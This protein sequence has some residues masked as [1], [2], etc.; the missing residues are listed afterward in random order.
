VTFFV[1]FLALAAGL[2]TLRAPAA[3]W[4]LR[5]PPALCRPALFVL[6]PERPG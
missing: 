2:A 3:A 1:V 4:R 6:V 5:V